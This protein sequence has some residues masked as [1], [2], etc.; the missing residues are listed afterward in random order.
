MGKSKAVSRM[1]KYVMAV[2][3]VVGSAVA[4]AGGHLVSTGH[5]SGGRALH[6]NFSGSSLVSTSRV[7]STALGS[8]GFGSTGFSTNGFRTAGFSSVAF[9]GSDFGGDDFRFGARSGL[10]SFSLESWT[11]SLRAALSALQPKTAVAQLPVAA[12]RCCTECT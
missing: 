6:G 10:S 12:P 9:Q 7:S 3:T 11:E 2:A 4:H 5:S 8:G 1:R